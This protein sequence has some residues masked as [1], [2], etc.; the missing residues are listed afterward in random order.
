MHIYSG[1]FDDSS[2]T[3]LHVSSLLFFVGQSKTLFGECEGCFVTDPA[4]VRLF[5]T[6]IAEHL[7][8]KLPLKAILFPDSSMSED[9]FEHLASE[10]VTLSQINVE[11]SIIASSCTSNGHAGRSDDDDEEIVPVAIPTNLKISLTILDDE[12]EDEDLYADTR[13]LF[14]NYNPYNVQ[15]MAASSDTDSTTGVYMSLK[16]LVRSGHEY[17][18]LEIVKPSKIYSD[19]S[20]YEMPGSNYEDM[21]MVSSAL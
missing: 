11:T 8:D 20:V 3:N 4:S 18:G 9:S 10:V 21:Y 19:D 12:C 15:S 1:R 7:K 5:P 16:Q 6:D 13:D 17:Q 2:T 14:N